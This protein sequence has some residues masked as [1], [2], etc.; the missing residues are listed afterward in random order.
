MSRSR[1]IC[2]AA[3]A[4]AVGA[5]GPAAA[6]DAKKTGPVTAEFKATLSGSQVTT[7]EYHNPKN[8][9]D[10]CS[11]SSNGYGD[12]TIR[13]DAKRTFRVKFTTPPRKQPNLF[14]TKGRPSVFTTPLFLNV[15]ARAERNGD[16]TVNYGEIDEQRCDAAS[17]GG[18]G[19][20]I[21]K[22]CGV[23]DGRFNVRMYFSD[24]SEDDGLL[25]PIARPLPDRNHLKLEGNFYEW[26]SADGT[27]ASTLDSTYQNCPLLLQDSYVERAGNIFTSP[28]KLSEKQLFN[29]R[30]KR[31]VV[32]G[33][34]IQP[35]TT[36]QTI[37]AWNL[38]L[39][40][41]K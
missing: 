36:G 1:S 24:P 2:I 17:G 26:F 9:D 39:K 10:P 38:R 6:A 15:D 34:H 19:G 11:A 22:D 33:H 8:Q 16:Y 37:L 14:G 13:F 27:S 21:A 3:A 29:R 28:A 41:V 20:D 23:R 35:H 7:W 5:I 4:L 31:I 18:G 25:I 40:R 12:Q 32:S 30:R